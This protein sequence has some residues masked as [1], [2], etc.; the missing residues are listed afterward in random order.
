MIHEYA[1][2]PS[3]LNSWATND[4]DY[5]EFLREYGLGT[6]RVIS[7]FPKSKGTKLRSFLL[8]HSPE[9]TQ[10]LA[11]QRYLEIVQ[12]VV[13]SVIIRGV[14]E[15]PTQDWIASVESENRRLAFSVILASVHTPTHNSVSLKTMYFKDSI[16]NH[17]RQLSFTRTNESFF[18]VIHNLVRL[19]HSKI[20]I[21]DPFGYTDEAFKFIRF[22]LKSISNNRTSEAF[23]SITLHYREN[24]GGGNG[25]GSPKADYVY[26]RL[27]F[28]TKELL[29]NLEL[30]VYEL[31]ETSEG[32]VF[33]NR[34][35]LTEHGGVITQHGIG[36]SG[37]EAHTDE[38]ILMEPSI[39][40]K[41]WKQFV[42]ANS[43]QIASEA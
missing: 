23:P 41:K 2:E 8:R 19:S 7:S 26:Q 5:A 4:R 20:V 37:S 11:G 43:Y 34:C 17:P 24:H 21:I 9:D 36:L 28:A 18:E 22:M 40:E 3:V 33:H 12:K 27:K 14:Q 31:R 29:P 39:Y 42:E 10:S 15:Q 16:W 13:E 30:K 32:D 1:L 25:G 6:P 38:A 35:I